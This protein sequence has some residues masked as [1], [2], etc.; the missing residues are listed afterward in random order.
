[1]RY[2]GGGV[3]HYRHN[4]ATS[5]DN[6]TT[7]IKD[8][9]NT[10]KV[11]LLEDQEQQEHSDA[12]ESDKELE[13]ENLLYNEVHG[14]KVENKDKEDGEDEDEDKEDKDEDEEDKLVGDKSDLDKNESLM[15]NN[16]DNPYEY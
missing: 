5:K 2:L 11:H 14:N 10:V 13:P 4:I 9:E 12:K 7:S 15:G 1:M 16:N 3:G 8:P 6:V